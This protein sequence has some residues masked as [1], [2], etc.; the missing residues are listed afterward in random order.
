MQAMQYVSPGLFH[1]GN[2]AQARALSIVLPMARGDTK[3][4]IVENGGVPL[5]ILLHD[6]PWHSIRLENAGDLKGV[7]FN[8]VEFEVDFSSMFDAGRHEMPIGCAIRR[9]DQ[10][11]IRVLAP[12][13]RGIDGVIRASVMSGLPKG[14][15]GDIAFTRWRIVK[16]V[17]DMIHVLH[18]VN[19]A[20]NADDD[21]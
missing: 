2:A 8:D 18:S 1:H 12:E 21:D 5:A 14:D 16:K 20:H 3:T 15:H 4:L 10:M 6:H 7:I 13:G 19:A 11:Y 17:E 9:G